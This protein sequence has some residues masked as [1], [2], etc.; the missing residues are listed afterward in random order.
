M[1]TYSV[2]AF[3]FFVTL[4]PFPGKCQTEADKTIGIGTHHL[5]IHIQGSGSPTVVIDSGLGDTMERLRPLQER[6]ATVTRVVTYNRAGYGQSGP[7]PLPRD[8]GREAEELKALLDSASVAGPYVIVGHSLGGLN[9]QVFAAKYPVDVA[10]LVLL[11]PPPL[12]FILGKTYPDLR[13]MADQMTAQW[14]AL[15]DAGSEST[16]PA[17]RARAAFF[18]AI[19]SEHREIFGESARLGAAIPSFGDTP[20][21]VIAA[22]RPNPFFGDVAEEYQRY[23]IEQSRALTQKSTHSTFVLAEEASHHL[24]ED[25]FDLVVERIVSV[26]QEARKK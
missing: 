14:Q 25:A 9:A 20:L 16:D 10:G 23:W 24:Y 22:G 3:F 2:I 7:G 13:V 19:A 11:D 17:E 21:V 6:L 18:Q 15:S 12:S 4:V 1:K 8:A 5:Q 26:V